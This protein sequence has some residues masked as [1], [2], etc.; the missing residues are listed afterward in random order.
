MTVKTAMVPVSVVA[1]AE[2]TSVAVIPASVPISQTAVIAMTIIVRTPV[3]ARSVV[4]VVPGSGAD[5][6]AADEVFRPV[7]AIWRA[8]VWVVTVVSIRTDWGSGHVART[9]PN[10][11]SHLRRRGG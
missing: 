9:D 5:K 11:D 3:V 4:A 10:A 2:S 7:V 6:D 8:G 1:A